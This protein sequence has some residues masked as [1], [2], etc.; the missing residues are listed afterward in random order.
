MATRIVWT[1]DQ[2]IEIARRSY[3]IK[4]DPSWADSDLEAV[5]VAMRE[6]IEPEKHRQLTQMQ[7]VEFVL[8]LWKQFRHHGMAPRTAQPAIR[9]VVAPAVEQDVQQKLASSMTLDRYTDAQI[10][11]EF[12]KRMAQMMDPTTQRAMMREEIN[13][14]LDRRLPGMLPPD[15]LSQ[16]SLVKEEVVHVEPKE[17]L[18]KVA[19]IG[20]Q[21][22]QSQILARKYRGKVDFHFLGGNEGIRRIKNT[23]ELMD[24]TFKTKWSKGNLDGLKVDRMT[25]VN[26]T[27]SIA[28]LLKDKFGLDPIAI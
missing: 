10:M 19:V 20:L 4:S 17:H 2:K 6:L 11:G 14:C 22:G 8:P 15:P 3:E 12:F 7:Q 27:D 26:G 9:P 28:R 24:F 18:V 1:K 16:P 21:G 13:A 23:V 25:N 5:R